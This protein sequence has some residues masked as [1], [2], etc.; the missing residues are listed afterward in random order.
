MSHSL[1]LD[2]LA[3]LYPFQRKLNASVVGINGYH[4]HEGPLLSGHHLLKASWW[5]LPGWELSM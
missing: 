4:T 3:L 1:R 5:H 2:L